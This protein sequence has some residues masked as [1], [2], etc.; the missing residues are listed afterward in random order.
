MVKED[1]MRLELD[2]L[3]RNKCGKSRMNGSCKH[4]NEVQV[5]KKVQRHRLENKRFGQEYRKPLKRREVRI[6]NTLPRVRG[7]QS[8]DFLPILKRIPKNHV[9]SPVLR[10]DLNEGLVSTKP[11]ESG[12]GFHGSQQVKTVESN[13]NSGFHG[14][15]QVKQI[16]INESGNDLYDDQW[17]RNMIYE[18]LIC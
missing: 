16:E 4:L 11:D 17:I 14:G 18:L 6:V 3:R 10:N 9:Y 15:R 12:D 8:Q 1:E 2:K 13:E 7:F 5:E